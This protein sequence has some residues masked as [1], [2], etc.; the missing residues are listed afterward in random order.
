MLQD[1]LKELAAAI[2][3]KDAATAKKLLKDLNR[4]GMDAQTALIL[5]KEIKREV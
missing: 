1:L 5:V 2:D 3:N 4:V